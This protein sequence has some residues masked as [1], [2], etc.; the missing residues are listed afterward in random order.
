MRFTIPLWLALVSV[1]G[2]AVEPLPGTRPLGEE[3][4]LDVMLMDGAHRFVERKIA[5]SAGG[6]SRWWR[7]DLSS[8]AA[9]EAS[10]AANRDRFR[11][12]IGAVDSRRAPAMEFFGDD[13]NPALAAETAAYRAYQ[14]RWPVLEAVNGE[15]LLFRPKTPP[16]AYVILLPDA[17]QTPE[18][19][20]GT[21]AGRL[22][23]SGCEVL[24]PALVD[25]TARW[26]GNPDIRMTDQPHREWIYRQAF[27]MGRHVIGYEAQ[28]ALAAVDWF[29]SRD[30]EA[31]VLV[32]GYGEGGLVAFYAAAADTRI[33][34]ALVSG[35]FGP[36]DRVWSEPIYRNVWGLLREFG[37]AELATLIAPRGLVVEHTQAPE[38]QG[39]KGDITTPAVD[40]ARAEYARI[41]G[42]LKPGFQR[43]EFVASPAPWSD[44][45]LRALLRMAGVRELAPRDAGVFEDRRKTFDPAARQRR[46]V[47]ELEAHVQNLVRVSEHV[48]RRFFLDKALPRFT[49]QKWSTLRRHETV[50]AQPFVES[51]RWYR[52]YLREEVLGQFDEP[53]LP[54]NA[55]TRK[56]YDNPKWAGYDVVL[57]VWPET[58]A[59][60]V[61]LVPKNVA[62]G[63]RRPVVVCQHGR[64]GVPA[65]VIEGDKTAYNNFGARL[66]DRGFVVFAPHNLY[67][68]E[69]R[70]RWLDRKANSVKASMFSVIVSQHD[71]ILRWLK[72]LPF[73]DGDR[74]GF[75]GLSYGGETAV[76]V[77]TVLEGYALSICSGDFNN[78]T[79]K[80]ASTDLPFGFMFTIEWEMPYFDMG[81]TFDYAELAYLMIPRPFM[82]ERGHHDLVSRDEWVAHEYAKVRWL[83]AQLGLADRTEIEYFNGGHSINGEGTF[84]FLHKHLRWPER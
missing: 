6:R 55:R 74:I 9:Y 64:Q 54:P 16:A 17:D 79:R 61:L 25:R 84:R 80:V 12:V 36:R 47:K 35:Y 78:W 51:A 7:R 72:T 18:E 19:I 40:A 20:A 62:P 71:Q 30:P 58:I 59:W 10:V 52:D 22:A 26:S 57:D 73:V 42:L 32:A 21:V 8:R 28:K 3:G 66:A 34:A 75:Y 37:D 46:Q 43:R 60:G 11:K 81:N 63:E 77:P 39:H 38:V 45:A 48:R 14:S 83:Y 23:A 27:H 31:K 56:I 2:A 50:Q 70:Y 68:G 15:G 53:L 65:D 29:K 76:R 69:D 5:E 1:P 41:E 67:R 24:V 13:D 33:D 49:D 44:T 82:A 4:A